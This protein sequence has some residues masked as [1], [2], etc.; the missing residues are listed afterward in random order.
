MS[1]PPQFSM[2]SLASA[3]PHGVGIPSSSASSGINIPSGAG[4][5]ASNPTAAAAQTLTA[6]EALLNSQLA[7]ALSTMGDAQYFEDSISPAQIRTSLASADPSNPTSTP[8]LLR[9]MKWLLASMSKGRD[10]SDFFPH[11]VKL[12]GSHS[13]EVR[14]MVYIY[15]SRYADFDPTCR[16]LALL[17]INSFQRGLAD[18]EPLIRA[19]ALRTMTSI[20]V[21][22]VLQIQIMAVQRCAADTSPYVRKCAANALTK[23]HPR[24]RSGD[25]GTGRDSLLEIM[26]KLLDEDSSTMV[27]TSALV[28]FT[29][30]CPERLDLLH[31]PYRKICH[32]L[33]DMDEWGQVVILDTLSRYCRKYFKEPRAR[34]RGSAEL[35]DRERRVRR[36][37]KGI[38]AASALDEDG[39]ADAAAAAAVAS[40]GGEDV[41]EALDELFRATNSGN[42]DKKKKKKDG[43][44][45]SAA[46]ALP[47]HPGSGGPQK[48]KRRV[49]KKAFYSDEEDESTEEEIYIGGSVAATMKQNTLIGQS[50]SEAGGKEGRFGP[51]IGSGVSSVGRMMGTADDDEYE[52]SELDEDHRLLLRS[53]LPLLKSRNS[54][55]V[56]AVCSL[57]YYCGVAS[58]R[59]RAAVGKSLVRI[60]RDKREIQ[61]V[62][63]TSIRTLVQECPSAF[64]PFLSDFFVKAMD[65]QFTRMIK[66][67]ILSSLCLDPGSIEA[68]LK[69]IRTY[70][71]H[72]DKDF[73]RASVQTVGKVAEMT[74]IV[75]DRRGAKT[76]SAVSARAD[77][78]LIALN[79]LYGLITLSQASDD[80]SVVGECVIVMENVMRQL[81]SESSKFSV[82]D[83]NKVQSQASKRLMQLLIWAL[84]APRSPHGG[85]E[86]E[87]AMDQEG[88]DALKN[89]KANTVLIPADAVASALSIIGDWFC[90]SSSSPL[91]TSLLQV[92]AKE[93]SRMRSEVLRLI[94]GK[95]ASMEPCEKLQCMHFASKALLTTAESGRT[96]SR[97]DDDKA[98]CEFILAMGRVDVIPDIRD[99]ARFESNLL[100]L[101]VGLTIDTD[102]LLPC[103]PDVKGILTLEDARAILLGTK[104]APSHLPVEE[105]DEV[106][107]RFGSLS[108]LLCHK[109]GKAYIPLP[110]WAEENSSGALRAPPE[111]SGPESK[112]GW[113][114]RTGETNEMTTGSFY[115][116]DA[117]SSSSDESSSGSSSDSDTDTYSD[118]S[119]SSYEDSSS[120]DESGGSSGESSSDESDA[121]DTTAMNQIR[122]N[123]AAI[124]NGFA[125]AGEPP[126]A[127]ASPRKNLA[128]GAGESSSSSEDESSSGSEESSSED[129][130]GGRAA[131]SNDLLDMSSFSISKEPVP[132]APASASAS[133]P[134]PIPI[135][136]E[137]K[138]KQASSKQAMNKGASGLAT[139]LEGLVMAPIVVD[140]DEDMNGGKADVEKESSQWKVLV[141]PE[142]SGGLQAKCRF[143]RGR[144]KD[145]ETQIMGF[146][147]ANSTVFCLQIKFENM[148]AD[149]G[150]LRRI[151]LIQRSAGGSGTFS[152]R[153]L[154]LPLEIGILKKGQ[155][156]CVLLG[157]E[158]TQKSDKDKVF[159]SKLE[160][161][162]DRGTNAFEIR[163]PLAETTLLYRMKR[164]EFDAAVTRLQGITQRTVSSFA[165]KATS[166]KSIQQLHA[167]LPNTIVKNAN[168]YPIDKKL[169][170]KADN[171]CDFAGRLPASETPIFVTTKAD[172]DTGVGSVVVHCDNLMAANA[173]A[174]FLK[175]SVVA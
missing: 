111:P 85:Y 27:L 174:D 126:T 156:S 97:S 58:I 71:R 157:L 26:A 24:C 106:S 54:G 117:E 30:L 152:P 160:V 86:E 141:R 170:W 43:K 16:E 89:L 155:S 82:S 33:T 46:S 63:L 132:G 158:F 149:S 95:M 18:G 65:P 32:L 15:L 161:K 60:Y 4:G 110:E 91:V 108:S 75:Y 9:G 116:D 142:L 120:D 133:A 52:D 98:L 45:S 100:N 105:D 143:L 147:T 130:N 11:V 83:P 23:L 113:K 55:V 39:A 2:S 21:R 169:G 136:A 36:T 122:A 67:D 56:L 115:D 123:G 70:I 53:S 164:P 118:S 124:V 68:V 114:V 135:P 107:L 87:E 48:I 72:N 50:G 119:E 5:A 109:A 64:T 129:D 159:L 62:V 93:K 6:A 81:L 1:A 144:T 38:A 171:S 25:G 69:E 88:D 168:L 14:K 99:R 167:D 153:R 57:H 59:I 37:V 19:L 13:L 102:A 96:S 175:R 103:P 150:V 134:I 145:R 92:T 28:A 162:S 47:P 7:S 84:D 101:C 163:P 128:L 139:G 10:V 42:G 172:P 17:A 34:S 154:S 3:L 20:R 140:K 121:D 77:A 78:D 73:V 74:R 12:V 151:R 31:K 138:P 90:A 137:T 165:L 173:F 22:D 166:G 41:G 94:S 125:P 104:H 35:I 127:I 66:L 112:D 76:G 8:A 146:D 49:V 148:R 80:S 79:C 61:Y 40:G 29:E 44:I 51:G 131:V